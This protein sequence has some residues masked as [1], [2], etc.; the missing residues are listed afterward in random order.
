MYSKVDGRQHN[1]ETS[2]DSD[3]LPTGMNRVA[4][5]NRVAPVTS[6][7]V[8]KCATRSPEISRRILPDTE[9]RWQRISIFGAE[10]RVDCNGC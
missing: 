10:T 9:N 1:L 5:D 3:L 2:T 8:L 6:K 4:M 7:I